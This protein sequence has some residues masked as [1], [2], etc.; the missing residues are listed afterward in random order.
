[1]IH[2]VG[3]GWRLGGQM[4]AQYLGHFAHCAKI[5]KYEQS[6]IGL[7]FL[8]QPQSYIYQVLQ[9]IQMKLIL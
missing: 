7:Q 5:Q 1:M 9:T 3:H 4:N 8:G 2:E 6:K